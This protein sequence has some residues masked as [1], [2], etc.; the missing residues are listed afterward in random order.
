MNC[1]L[2]GL[3][4][5]NMLTLIKNRCNILLILELFDKHLNPHYFERL[6]LCG[7]GHTFTY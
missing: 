5:R 1:I 6:K 4:T 2:T 7:K 3:R